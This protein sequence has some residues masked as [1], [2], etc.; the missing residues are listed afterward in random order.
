MVVVNLAAE[1]LLGHAD[2]R[3]GARDHAVDGV[4]RV[5]PERQTHG[6]AFAVGFAVG[7]LVENAVLRPS[8]AICSGESMDLITM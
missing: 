2:D 3:F 6:A 1:E 8:R 5:V 7:V 4:G